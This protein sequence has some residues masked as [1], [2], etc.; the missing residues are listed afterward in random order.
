MDAMKLS[1][2]I[3]SFSLFTAVL[4][5]T[6]GSVGFLGVRA[7]QR[8]MTSSTVIVRDSIDRQNHELV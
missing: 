3:W 8:S 7:I 4:T 5:L 1:T 2:R 6:L